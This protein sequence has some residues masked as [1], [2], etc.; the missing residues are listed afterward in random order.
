[1]SE[2]LWTAGTFAIRDN[3]MWF[4]PTKF[5]ALC[6]YNLLTHNVDKVVQFPEI[7]RYYASFL[8]A[9]FIDEEIVLAPGFEQYFFTYNPKDGIENTYRIGESDDLGSYDLT[10][11]IEDKTYV[12]PLKASYTV[13]VERS[14]NGLHF[15]KITGPFQ[16]V[17]S[18]TRIKDDIY[19]VSG[20]SRIGCLHSLDNSIHTIHI[21]DDKTSYET[22][23]SVDDKRILTI[24]INGKGE[25]HDLQD[26]DKGGTGVFDVG[27]K[28]YSSINMQNK[29]YL[30]LW[31]NP[32]KYIV[33][34]MENWEK[35][36]VKIK[37]N[38][39]YRDSNWCPAFSRP[40]CA[41]HI[42]YVMATEQQCLLKIN[43]DKDSYETE[44]I[45][46]NDSV[47][48]V[49]ARLMTHFLDKEILKEGD[50]YFFSVENFLKAINQ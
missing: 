10:V 36:I 24:D 35:T 13:C 11:P 28:I 6:A 2:K 26:M 1:M 46:R 37:E 48:D 33:V 9:F 49:E 29:L 17:T 4:L 42:I 20:D 41:D 45:E 8:N 30:F 22:I 38:K 31:D 23:A 40:V 3:I 32:D 25:V 18:V 34:D 43:T 44:Y 5:N 15:E 12:F 14:S 39:Y 47:R 21:G 27:D 19:F 50:P 16:T 7:C